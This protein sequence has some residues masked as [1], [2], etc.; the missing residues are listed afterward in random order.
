MITL[1]LGKDP[2]GVLSDCLL[3]HL[4]NTTRLRQTRSHSKLAR[5]V[6]EGDGPFNLK[7]PNTIPVLKAP[8]NHKMDK[9]SGYFLYAESTCAPHGLVGDVAVVL[10]IVLDLL[11]HLLRDLDPVRKTTVSFRGVRFTSPIRWSPQRSKMSCHWQ[12]P[13]ACPSA[14]RNFPPFA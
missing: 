12:A 1:N 4:Q 8:R 10:V 5:S 14:V 2:T 9:V 3:L 6:R 13:A 11:D 7:P